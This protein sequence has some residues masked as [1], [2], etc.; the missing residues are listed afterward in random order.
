[1][2]DLWCGYCGKF[3][4]GVYEDFIKHLH[5]CEIECCKKRYGGNILND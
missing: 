4:A 3:I 1:M 5:I 2:K